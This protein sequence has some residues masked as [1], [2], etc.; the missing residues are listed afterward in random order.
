MEQDILWKQRF[1]SYKKA[2]AQLTEGIAEFDNYPKNIV[3]EGV[4]QRFE[5]TH[6]LAW[7]VMKDYLTLEGSLNITGSRSSTREAFN[8]GLIH[9]GES[10]MQM[11]ES[12][13]ITVHTY[14][15]EILNNEYYNIVNIYYPLLIEFQETMEAFAK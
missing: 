5:F 9:D 2:L 13:N 1:D 8:K 3:K 7:N 14:D 11:L 12:R 4:I 10:W 6:E 15:E